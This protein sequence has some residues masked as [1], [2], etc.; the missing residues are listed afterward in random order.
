MPRKACFPWY[1]FVQVKKVSFL[2]IEV[3]LIRW[4]GMSPGEMKR[5]EKM[6]VLQYMREQVM[7]IIG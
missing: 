1:F 5:K 2:A 4:S 3:E 7:K 6:V